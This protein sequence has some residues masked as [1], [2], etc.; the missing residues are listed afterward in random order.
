MKRPAFQFYPG[1]WLKDPALTLCSPATR[2]IWIDLLCAMHELDQTGQ[3]TGTREQLARTGR[4]SLV[5]L[6]QALADLS[7]TGAAT[8]TVRHGKVTVINRRMKRQYDERKSNADRQK[9]RRAKKRNGTSCAK[10]TRYSSSSSSPSVSDKGVEYKEREVKKRSSLSLNDVVSY[11][12]ERMSERWPAEQI[13]TS[14]KKFMDVHGG[15]EHWEVWAD[16][17]I[18]T[19]RPA[20]VPAGRC[21]YRTITV[22]RGC[23]RL[24]DD[25]VCD[26]PDEDVLRHRQEM[27]YTVTVP[28]DMTDGQAVGR[29][30][31]EYVEA[32]QKEK[33]YAAV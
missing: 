18:D 32:Q 7:D 15:K 4:C 9:R 30:K 3:I 23:W 10:V 2:G 22:C 20:D 28:A 5:E 21:E 27:Q 13:E 17:W 33:Q 25:C 16:Q 29:A 1:D 31:E 12:E 26:V 19:E 11:F 14:A 24:Y 6:D 8:V